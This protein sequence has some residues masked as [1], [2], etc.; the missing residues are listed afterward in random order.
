MKSCW[1][2]PAAGVDVRHQTL[3]GRPETRR[4]SAE[5][6]GC[7][8]AARQSGADDPAG[9]DGEPKGAGILAVVVLLLLFICRQLLLSRSRSKINGRG[10]TMKKS[11]RLGSI[12]RAGKQR[13]GRDGGAA[14]APAQPCPAGAKL[15]GS[16]VVFG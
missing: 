4:G 13:R 1:R 15:G 16:A 3:A 10:W 6:G 2:Q 12:T 5:P 11:K 8:A 14:G 9:T 7:A